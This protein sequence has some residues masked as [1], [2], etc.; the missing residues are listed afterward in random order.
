MSEK[1][2]NEAEHVEF[3]II[4][5][6]YK[7]IFPSIWCIEGWRKRGYCFP[8]LCLFREWQLDGRRRVV[9]GIY[10]M[11]HCCYYRQADYN[12]T[13]VWTDRLS[14]SR[15]PMATQTTGQDWP[16]DGEQTEL[17]SIWRQTTGKIGRTV[18]QNR[19]SSWLT[20]RWQNW[21]DNRAKQIVVT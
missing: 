2:K 10:G 6:I 17:S 12:R 13:H 4:Y 21:T 1:T 9:G 11:Q 14:K 8:V 16:D 18:E 5:T 7:V 15:L 3:S 20:T 19:L